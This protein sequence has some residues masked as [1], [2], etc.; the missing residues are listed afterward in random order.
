MTF[1]PVSF[2]CE[3]GLQSQ[4]VFLIRSILLF[5]DAQTPEAALFLTQTPTSNLSDIWR[6][7]HGKLQ[8]RNKPVFFW[9]NHVDTIISLLVRP[10]NCALDDMQ[11]QLAQHYIIDILKS[12][13]NN[14]DFGKIVATKFQT[15]LSHEANCVPWLLSKENCFWAWK[16]MSWR[17]F[18]IL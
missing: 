3:P 16:M 12:M 15:F 11:L 9:E 14:H 17:K 10:P 4:I 1:L 7:F 6:M 8:T 18:Q 2:K 13:V 5:P